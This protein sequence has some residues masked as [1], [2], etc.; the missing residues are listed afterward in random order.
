MLGP[1]AEKIFQGWDFQKDPVLLNVT[2]LAEEVLLCLHRAVV[3][4]G[5]T[6]EEV[7][8]RTELL[9]VGEAASETI[10]ISETIRR[11]SSRHYMSAQEDTFLVIK[12]KINSILARSSSFN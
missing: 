5:G 3:A 9:L 11:I 12:E 1:L 6:E 10:D 2:D 8:S 7:D 4:E